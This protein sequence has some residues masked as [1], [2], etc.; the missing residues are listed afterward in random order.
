VLGAL[1]RLAVVAEAHAPRQGASDDAVR[2]T[3]AAFADTIV[4]GPAGG[5]DPDPGAIEAGV[6]EEMH[7]PFY[8]AAGIFPVL[9]A[10]L[11]AATPVVLGRPATFELAVPYADRER[12]LLDRVRPVAGG[13]NATYLL[14]I[15]V[16]ILVWQIYYG[17]AASNAGVDYMR[18]PPH[19]NGYWPDH[20]YRIRFRGMTR[21][22][23]PR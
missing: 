21:D 1:E 8:G 2:R 18:L 4:P 6:V 14:H 19:S 5:A 20:S 11:Q 3:I 22:G 13:G 23:N 7:A 12:V 15:A 17:V 10:D 16:A 9:H